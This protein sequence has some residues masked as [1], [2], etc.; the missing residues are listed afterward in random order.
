MTKLRLIL[1][2]FVSLL[3]AS[4]GAGANAA[5]ESI[6]GQ[7]RFVGERVAFNI[8]GRYTNYVLTIS[9][10]EGYRARAEGARSA[11]TIRL[12][13]HGEVVDGLYTYQLTAATDRVDQTQ[14]RVDQR[15]NGR[16]P[17]SG[18]PM[19]GA[20]MSGNFRVEEGRIRIF[21]DLEEPPAEG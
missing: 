20:S 14:A 2:P 16:E 17:G 3:F 12:A 13:D 8:Q 7:A 21:E 5:D 10:P 6:Q 18:T 11:P 4:I 1:I 15:T 9:G 19:V